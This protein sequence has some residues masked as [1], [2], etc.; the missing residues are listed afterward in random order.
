MRSKLTRKA[1]YIISD[2]LNLV[3]PIISNYY[4]PPLTTHTGIE[5][6]RNDRNRKR[7]AIGL[8]HHRTVQLTKFCN[9]WFINIVS[10]ASPV[11]N[12]LC[13]QELPS[14]AQ[15]S[16]LTACDRLSSSI[17]LDSK[18]PTSRGVGWDLP[19]WTADRPCPSRPASNYWSVA[20]RITSKVR[21]RTSALDQFVNKSQ[22]C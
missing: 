12:L 14:R 16:K 11:S 20:V 18:F 1:S 8:L 9:P 19:F 13:G 4:P 5:A 17:P 10:S 2:A 7:H 6:D 21:K 3:F 15:Q 22:C